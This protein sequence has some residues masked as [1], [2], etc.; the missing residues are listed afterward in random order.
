M[1]SIQKIRK[2]SLHNTIIKVQNGINKRNL[3]SIHL[4]SNTSVHLQWANQIPSDMILS[5]SNPKKYG[6]FKQIK[7]K[8]IKSY[9]P[10]HLY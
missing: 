5:R 6:K 8:S 7:Q 9:P 1:I 10:I 3:S 2:V 4:C